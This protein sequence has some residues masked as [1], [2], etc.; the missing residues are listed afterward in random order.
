MENQVSRLRK[1]TGTL[2]FCVYLSSNVG[3]NMDVSEPSD[4]M[5]I[6][7]YAIGKGKKVKLS[8]CLTN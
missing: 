6:I 3:G 5:L 4:S 7:I 8:L 2:Q 1:T